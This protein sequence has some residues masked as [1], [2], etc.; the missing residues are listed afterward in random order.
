MIELREIDEGNFHE[1][2]S[3][4]VSEEDQVN[5]SSVQRSLAE[6]WLYRKNG[7]VFPYALYAGNQLVGFVLLDMDE[8]ESCCMIWRLLIDEQFQGKGYGQA[9][10]HTIIHLATTMGEFSYVRADYV[11]GNKRMQ[12]LLHSMGFEQ[13]GEDERELFTR[14]MVKEKS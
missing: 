9:A 6:A 7:D 10:I 2:I 3:L 1:V 8:E 4:S 11:K 14:R 5:V 12:H 13:F